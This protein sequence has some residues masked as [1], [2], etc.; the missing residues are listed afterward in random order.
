MGA[1]TRKKILLFSSTIMIGSLTISPLWVQAYYEEG[2]YYDEYYDENSGGNYDTVSPSLT[3]KKL[4]F[5]K[6]SAPR[7][8]TVDR[9]TIVGAYSSDYN[10]A[11]VSYDGMVTPL[12]EGTAT[13]TVMVMCEDYQN[14][15]LECEVKV[16]SLG[17]S[18]TFLELNLNQENSRT[19]TITG[20][21]YE[22]GYEVIC[23]MAD[24]T[25]AKVY[26]SG[27]TINIWGI[28]QGQTNLT[29]EIAGQTFSC[30]IIISGY[31]LNESDMSIAKGKTK[32]LKVIGSQSPVK[33]T[34]KNT[35]IATVSQKGVVKALGTGVVTIIAETEGMNLSCLVSVANDKAIKAVAKAKSAIGAKYSQKK[36][37]EEGY[38]DC[39]SL[40]WRSYQPYGITL[41]SNNWAPTAADQAKWCA[42]HKKIIADETKDL[43]KVKLVPGDLIFY[44]NVNEKNGRY[45][46]I[47]HVAMFAGYDRNLV[48]GWE[49][50]LQGTLVE[51]DG[52]KVSLGNYHTEYFGGK[53]IVSIARP[54]K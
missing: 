44:S 1:K 46:D 28:K 25:V 11:S 39:S 26:A 12:N 9:G 36:R 19:I 32:T 41:G 47:Y 27:N 38:Y 14:Y 18:D 48:Y 22:D 10:V 17:L 3:E 50:D 4:T 53:K 23:N 40:I 45:K 24:P 6:G 21:S 33:W 7:P 37:M 49:S 52:A 34:S 15:S 2:Y 31:C 30:N 54:I 35:K 42:D 8:V 5:L 29:V 43:S 51:A 13:I 20:Y 16:V